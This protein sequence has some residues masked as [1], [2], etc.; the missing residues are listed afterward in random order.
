MA[1]NIIDSQ[2]KEIERLQKENECLQKEN[3]QLKDTVKN[4]LDDKIRL[5]Q[6]RSEL[7]L[8]NK[9]LKEKYVYYTATIPKQCQVRR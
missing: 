6:F 5:Q 2:R 1:T 9:K 3:E 4:L 8:E 7:D